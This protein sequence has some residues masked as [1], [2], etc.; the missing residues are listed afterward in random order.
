LAPR[1]PEVG[2]GIK[3]LAILNRT[4]FVDGLRITSRPPMTA[5]VTG[6]REPDEDRANPCDQW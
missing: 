2:L 5:T 1:L 6:F 4:L 3:A